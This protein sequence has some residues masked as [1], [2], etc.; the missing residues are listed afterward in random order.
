MNKFD[1]SNLWTRQTF[2]L[3]TQDCSRI[4]ALMHATHAWFDAGLSGGRDNEF[5]AITL[6]LHAVASFPFGAACQAGLLA[7]AW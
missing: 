5:A 1:P 2:P 3:V 4:D 6:P 7:A